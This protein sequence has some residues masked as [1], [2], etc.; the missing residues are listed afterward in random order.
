MVVLTHRAR[1]VLE[2]TFGLEDRA[3]CIAVIPCCVDRERFPDREP[4]ADLAQRYDLSDKLVVGNLGAINNRYLLHEMFR[5]ISQLKE[6][7]PQLI[8][9][10][11]TR[12]DPTALHSIAESAG[13]TRDDVLPVAATP[14]QVP[15]WLSLFQLG[16]FFLK[17]SYAAQGSC[18][19]KLGEFLA[20]G[21]PVVTNAGV[22]D[23]QQIL[24]GEAVGIVL[25][26]FSDQSIGA[27]AEKAAALVPVSAELRCAC[28]KVSE[29]HFALETGC[30]NYLSI[31]RSLLE[32]NHTNQL[33]WSGS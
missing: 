30:A 2:T 6:R 1:E 15:E 16:V 9:V 10:Y 23:V 4:S 28:R 24:E 17:P 32:Q 8:F 31:Y 18:F 26:E 21:V 20:A 25:R 27:A 19:T 33:A 22:G 7:L 29:A 14:E 11:I 12:Q 5:F 3:E 13:L